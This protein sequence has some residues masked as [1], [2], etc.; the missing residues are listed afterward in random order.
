MLASKHSQRTKEFVI[1]SLLRSSLIKLQGNSEFEG[2]RQNSV[3]DTIF[4][5][6]KFW[7]LLKALQFTYVFKTIFFFNNPLFFHVIS[8]KLWYIIIVFIYNI[9]H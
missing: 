3:G 4:Y 6:L 8:Q 5:L 2:Q 9:L 7:E 1:V